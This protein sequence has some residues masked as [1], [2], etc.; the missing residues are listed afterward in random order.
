MNI[1]KRTTFVIIASLLLLGCKK[2]NEPQTSNEQ[3]P[4]EVLTINLEQSSFISSGH[5]LVAN[6]FYF[7]KNGTIDR[8]GFH[9]P[10]PGIYNVMLQQAKDSRTVASANITIRQEDIGKVVWATI[11]PVKVV[12]EYEGDNYENRYYITYNTQGKEQYEYRLQERL[13]RTIGDIVIQY[14]LQRTSN[15]LHGYILIGNAG[16]WPFSVFGGVFNFIPD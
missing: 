6:E 11:P 3:I 2:E 14:G 1:P 7:R 13:P 15:D 8:V 4:L 16:G 5:T 9:S 12:A 10:S